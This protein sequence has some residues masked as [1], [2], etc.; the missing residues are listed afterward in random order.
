[1]TILPQLEKDLY[2][3]ARQR[4]PGVDGPLAEP[5][6]HD[7]TS[8]VPTARW[9]LF[10]G[11]PRS[12]AAVLPVLASI[13]VVL[14]IAAAALT[15]RGHHSSTPARPGIVKNGQIAVFDSSSSLE[16]VNR[17][18][19]RLR[20]VGPALCHGEGC[21]AWSR[22]GQQLAYLAGSVPERLTL[23]LVGADGQHPR[24]LTWCGYCQGVSWSPDGSQIAVER[25]VLPKGPAV[26]GASNVWVVNAETG[27]MRPITHCQVGACVDFEF[28]PQ[29]QW[30]PKGGEVLFLRRRNDNLVSLETIRPDGSHPTTITTVTYPLGGGP[31]GDAAGPA[32][33]WSPDGREIA[34][35]EHN[36][37]YIINAD[38]TGLRRLVANG[39]FPAWSPNGT[40]LLY[41]T[42]GGSRWHGHIRLWTIDANGSDNRLLSRYLPPNDDQGS[43]WSAHVWSPDGRQIA[44]S[45]PDAYACQ[46][47]PS[48]CSSQTGTFVINADGTGLH[49]I[50][51]SSAELAWQPI[52]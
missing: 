23:Y 34:F 32:P 36:G 10:R 21:V 28:S 40:R 15:L 27:A 37:I 14:V 7:H 42:W 31:N 12:S 51:P 46:Q 33:Q 30:S 41:A 44:F 49:R 1:M 45:T 25:L 18:G 26:G 38:G 6:R 50:G 13:I 8:T 3:A 11:R 52:P 9:P 2:E 5:G 39:A 17:D 48:R 22:D 47:L 29:L 35:N 16:F 20:D 43:Y 4:L 19:S 24:R